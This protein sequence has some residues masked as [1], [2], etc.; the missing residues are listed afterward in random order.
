MSTNGSTWRMGIWA[1]LLQ[2]HHESLGLRNRCNMRQC[3]C[4]LLAGFAT[5][6]EAIDA[7]ILF[8]GQTHRTEK[9]IRA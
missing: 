7:E 8:A 4:H 1:G 6:G 3:N 5:Q 9:P 2:A